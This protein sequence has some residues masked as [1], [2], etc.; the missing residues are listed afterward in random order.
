VRYVV[1][2]SSFVICCVLCVCHLLPIELIVEL[3]FGFGM[4]ISADQLASI[5]VERNGRLYYDE[6][7]ATDVHGHARKQTLT[8][9][10]F[11]RTLE[12][13]GSNGYWN[14]NHMTVQTEDCIDCLHVF[15]RRN[16]ITYFLTTIV[17]VTQ[18]SV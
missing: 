13:G 2:F 7:A 11:V 9:S 1:A 5:N 10:P 17:A 16:M 18:R 8:T 12:F 6:A 15:F 3:K 4:E 14:G